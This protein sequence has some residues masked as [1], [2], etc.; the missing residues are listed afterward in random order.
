M[1]RAP[2]AGAYDRTGMQTFADLER[3][4]PD[5]AAAARA[6]LWVPGVGF[7]YLATVRQDGAPRIHPVNV[8]IVDGRLFAFLVPSPK[9]GD[10]VR[11]GRFA[12]H[13]TGS[14]TENDELAITGRAIAHQDERRRAAVVAAMPFAVSPDHE[15][16]E[17][18]L[19][20]VLWAHYATPPA[21]PP[22]YHRWPARPGTRTGPEPDPRGA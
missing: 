6:L 8:T 20:T 13:T 7:G 22:T 12:L 3:E 9:R 18:G 11:D 15:L 14:E 1:I 21:F 19:E 5:M 10:L 17:L 4:R 16:F 2:G